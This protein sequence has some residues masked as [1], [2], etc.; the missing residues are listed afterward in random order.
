MNYSTAYTK[1]LDRL[2]LDLSMV[3]TE[4]SARGFAVQA[5]QS[6]RNQAAT[7][8]EFYIGEFWNLFKGDVV[9]RGTGELAECK[10][11]RKDARLE[12]DIGTVE[13]QLRLETATAAGDRE[14]EHAVWRE[15]EDRQA[16]CQA[17]LDAISQRVGSV[18]LRLDACSHLA[19]LLGVGNK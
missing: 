11:A 6:I 17:R 4:E 5:A 12:A 2:T 10:Q 8:Q 16:A 14:A 13:L 7:V 19:S 18:S 1:L 15:R 9:R 3:E